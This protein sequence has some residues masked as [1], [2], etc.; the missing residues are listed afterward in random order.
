MV[1]D[2]ECRD[3]PGNGCSEYQQGV[4]S[5][6]TAPLTI[7]TAATWVESAIAFSPGAANT[8]TGALV[9][10]YPAVAIPACFDDEDHNTC[11]TGQPIAFRI[12]FTNRDP[13]GRTVTLWPGSAMS[14][15]TVTSAGDDAAHT[16][17]FYIVDGLNSATYPSGVIAYNSTQNFVQLPPDVPTTLYFASTLQL[18]T[19]VNVVNSQSG[20]PYAALFTLTGQFSDN[21]LY[22]QTIPFPAGIVT[23]S[24]ATFSATSG[25]NG[26][27]ITITTPLCATKSINCFLP[28]RMAMV[29]WIDS[30]NKIVVLKTFT[31]DSTGNIASVTFN[32]PTASAGWYTVALT[33]YVNTYFIT[34]NHT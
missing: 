23:A 30:T 3:A 13:Q 33:D 28:S 1:E 22:G 20:V 19:T 25:G 34:F 26:A 4:S 24:T 18:G 27:T 16:S 32:I 10:G 8:Q 12:A 15:G 6:N 21:T 14:V 2:D 5:A 29:G 31:T 11:G 7:N 9:N 17:P